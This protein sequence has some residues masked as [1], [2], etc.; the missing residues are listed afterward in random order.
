MSAALAHGDH[1]VAARRQ[2][3][4][5]HDVALGAASDEE[6]SRGQD[7]ALIVV[8]KAKSHPRLL[9]DHRAGRTGRRFRQFVQRAQS[10]QLWRRNAI[11][12]AP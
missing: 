1:R 6:L 11:R 3:I 2:R 9:P 10:A 7:N 4:A 12:L 5:H 8:P